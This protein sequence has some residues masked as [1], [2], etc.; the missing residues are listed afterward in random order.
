LQKA[1]ELLA[2]EDELLEADGDDDEESKDSNME[3][4]IPPVP[5][6]PPL[7]RGVKKPNANGVV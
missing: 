4:D 3:D 5:P 1:A 2:Q 7:P 6:V